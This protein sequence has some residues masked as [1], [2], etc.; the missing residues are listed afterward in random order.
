M[1]VTELVFPT[2]KPNVDTKPTT[3]EALKHFDNVEGLLLLKIGNILHANGDSLPAEKSTVLTLGES[4]S[5][6]LAFT[7]N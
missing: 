6:I 1:P 3:T 5:E 7:V 4:Q 2:F